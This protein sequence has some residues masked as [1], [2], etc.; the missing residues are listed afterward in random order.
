[1]ATNGNG[2]TVFLNTPI[3]IF[4]LSKHENTLLSPW[5]R[6]SV[7]S[8]PTPNTWWS[9]GFPHFWWLNRVVCRWTPNSWCLNHGILQRFGGWIMLNPYLSAGEASVFHGTNWSDLWW[10]PGCDVWKV[11]W[12]IDT[13]VWE[14]FTEQNGIEAIFAGNL[15]M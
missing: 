3:W 15:L 7:E 14:K 10:P 13:D 8:P 11:F 9:L 12:A 1:M 5:H 4:G 6:R 2:N